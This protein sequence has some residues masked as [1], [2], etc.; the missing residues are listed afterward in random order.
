MK[1]LLEKLIKFNDYLRK[2]KIIFD[3]NINYNHLIIY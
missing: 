1:N 2:N 3:G